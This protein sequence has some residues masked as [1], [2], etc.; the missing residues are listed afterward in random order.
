MSR[1]TSL[2]FSVLVFSIFYGSKGLSGI[3]EQPLVKVTSEYNRIKVNGVPVETY[4]IAVQ[5][6]NLGISQGEIEGLKEKSGLLLGE[7]DGELLPFLLAQGVN[8]VKAVDVWY[9]QQ[10]FPDNERGNQLR[11]FYERYR[12]FLLDA[13]ARNLP[14]PDDS[15]DFIYCHRLMNNL[16]NLSPDTSYAVWE[17]AIR[18]LKPGGFARISHGDYKVLDNFIKSEV[19][20][21]CLT[22]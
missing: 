18:V 13:D 4:P 11:N 15:Q 21:F 20:P 6:K 14:V 7:G 5:F 1:N 3:C 16:D 10:S 8:N 2:W 17:E 9:H 12:N 22:L 19:C